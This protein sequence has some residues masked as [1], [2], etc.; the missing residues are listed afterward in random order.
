MS[1][2]VTKAEP[3]SVPAAEFFTPNQIDLIKRQICPGASDDELQMFIADCRRS[4]LDP[5]SRQIYSIERRERFKNPNGEWRWRTKR[6]TQVSIDGFRL[7][8]ER[9]G[10]YAGQ[11]GPEWCDID[12]E[13]LDVWL[14]KTDLRREPAAARVG[15]LRKEFEKPL[16]SV[17]VF[18]EY[19]PKNDEGKPTGL[20]ARMPA[21]MIAKCAEALALRRAFPRELSGLYTAD[22]MMQ[23]VPVDV[24]PTRPE[25]DD[26]FPPDRDE[27]TD[28]VSG[29]SGVPAAAIQ[30][31]S[32]PRAAAGAMPF[33][34][35]DAARDAAKRG[36]DALQYFFH[37]R[38]AAEK[39]KLRR[40]EAELV[41]LYPSEGEE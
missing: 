30:P 13:W 37:Q 27:D 3:G 21:V 20:W 41:A 31:P 34:L 33:N 16:W 22:E 18:S 11:L 2:A 14:P 23:A 39:A 4:Q 1:K 15:V 8:A 36:R 40:I 38:S 9:T 17:A 29:A 24:T 25:P 35:E 26:T 7:I 32:Q 28:A 19:C 12:R 6:T 5:F 10:D